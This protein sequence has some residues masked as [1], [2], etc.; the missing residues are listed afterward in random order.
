M[1]DFVKRMKR[2]TTY[3]DKIFSNH[4]SNKIFMSI[5][6][7]EHSKF[8]IKK[9]NNLIKKWAKDMTRHFRTKNLHMTSMHMLG[10]STL[11]AIRG[12]QIKPQ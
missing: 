5:I 2:Q 6:Y 9:T 11:L 4:I 12:M 10:R 3:W 7:K 8:Y 1:K